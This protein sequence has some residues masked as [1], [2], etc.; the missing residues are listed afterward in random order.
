MPLCGADSRWHAGGCFDATGGL[1][2]ACGILC[3]HL[4]GCTHNQCRGWLLGLFA[5]HVQVRITVGADTATLEQV[6][7]HHSLERRACRLLDLAGVRLGIRYNRACCCGDLPGVP[8]QWS[9]R[10]LSLLQ[11]IPTM[12]A[13]IL[14]PTM[15]KCLLVRGWKATSGWGFPR[16]KVSKDE[17]DAEC[18]IRE[19]SGWRAAATLTPA[20]RLLPVKTPM[21]PLTYETYVFCI[22]SIGYRLLHVAYMWMTASMRCYGMHEAASHASFENCCHHI[23]MQCPS[24]Q[25]QVLERQCVSVPGI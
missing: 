14:D 3:T 12:G 2:H 8:G 9:S 23:N 13:I 7:L 24:V 18:A 6:C 5:K 20:S 1:R 4:S 10:L 17:S 15:E 25:N 19:V 21:G 16:G 11:T 22:I